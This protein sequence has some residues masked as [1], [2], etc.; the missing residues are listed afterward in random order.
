SYQ[1]AYSKALARKISAAQEKR[2][3]GVEVMGVTSD[4]QLPP[5]AQ[6]RDDIKMGQIQPNKG[7]ENANTDT[8][9][10]MDDGSQ[11]DFADLPPVIL[12]DKGPL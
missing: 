1:L 9:P 6:P 2:E 4:R 5:D 10:F 3:H 8:V 7:E 11:I 12:P